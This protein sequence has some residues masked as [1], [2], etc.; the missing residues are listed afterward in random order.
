MRS[1][2]K[3]QRSILSIED[4][5]RCS[6][7]A[8]DETDPILGVVSVS[9]ETYYGTVDPNNR[10]YGWI[11]SVVTYGPLTIGRFTDSNSITDSKL[12]I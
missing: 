4:P 9:N 2:R 3:L 12:P 6:Q 10:F 7:I 8:L 5:C 11:L 1:V